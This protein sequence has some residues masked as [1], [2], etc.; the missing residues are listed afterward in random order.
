[1]NLA[2]KESTVR[3]HC[4]TNDV[5]VS[6]LET[7]PG[8]GVRLVCSSGDGAA[9]LRE[10]LKNNLMDANAERTRIRPDKPLW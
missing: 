7:L 10:V 9:R 6:V 5:E 3:R 2:L 1:M 8:G 4:K